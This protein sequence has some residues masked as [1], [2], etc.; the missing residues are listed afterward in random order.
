[1]SLRKLP[2]GVGT[3]SQACESFPTTWARNRNVRKP[4][5]GVG[6]K[7]QGKNESKKTDA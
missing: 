7:S 1:M 3:K 4:P 6:T 5:H 2:H